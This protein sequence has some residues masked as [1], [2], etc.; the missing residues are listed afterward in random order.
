MFGNKISVD[1]VFLNRNDTKLVVDAASHCLPAAFLDVLGNTH[2]LFIE[3][4]CLAIEECLK[5]KY[6]RYVNKNRLH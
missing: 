3:I 4:V 2:G 1:L 6:S 5:S